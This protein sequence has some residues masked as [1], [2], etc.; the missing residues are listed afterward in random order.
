QALL[1]RPTF[2]L[3]ILSQ[4]EQLF[5]Q[6]A[7]SQLAL[8]AE[9]ACQFGST[10]F[11]D[12]LLRSQQGR[13]MFGNA[14]KSGRSRA[15][16]AMFFGTL[17]LL[18]VGPNLVDVFDFELSENMRVSANQLTADMPS[19]GFEIKRS[20]LSGELTVKNHLQEQVT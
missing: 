16:G 11:L 14:V 9:A 20:T 19:D 3:G 8:G 12:E 7:A 13:Q 4:F 1:R 15:G 10:R 5:S 2:T 6:L 17:N 18:P